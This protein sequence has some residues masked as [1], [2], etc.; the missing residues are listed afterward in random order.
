MEVFER[1]SAVEMYGVWM[2]RKPLKNIE[3]MP[4][5]PELIL[6]VRPLKA[7]AGVEACRDKCS[8]CFY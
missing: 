4:C 3:A 7:S 6:D 5:A 2:G 1:C 8:F